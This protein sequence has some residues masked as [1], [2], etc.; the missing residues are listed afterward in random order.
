[1]ST[2]YRCSTRS[3]LWR[4]ASPEASYVFGTIVPTDG[5]WTL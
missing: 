1:M 2:E 3:V 5:G 4:M